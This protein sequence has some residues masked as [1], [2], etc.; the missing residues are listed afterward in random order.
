ML[1]GPR[2]NLLC[3]GLFSKKSA[4]PPKNVWGARPG[5]LL[6]TITLTKR[7]AAPLTVGVDGLSQESEQGMR[8]GTTVPM[9]QLPP[10][11]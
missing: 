7:P 10:Q 5:S 4:G 9:P 11:L 2:E 3:M 1:K 6:P 8:C